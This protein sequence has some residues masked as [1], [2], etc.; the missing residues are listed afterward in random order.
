ME[1]SSVVGR[2]ALVFRVN[3]HTHFLH[4]SRARNF[5]EAILWHG[6]EALDSKKRFMNFS[7]NQRRKLIAFLKSL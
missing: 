2:Q 1:N 6:G 4:D 5:E 7:S 3:R